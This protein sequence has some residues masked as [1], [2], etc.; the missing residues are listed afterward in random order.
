M[1][2]RLRFRSNI[3][4]GGRAGSRPCGPSDLRPIGVA[5]V[6]PAESALIDLDDSD[7]ELDE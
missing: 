6:R 2:M 5:G 3:R 7:D 4:P 1:K